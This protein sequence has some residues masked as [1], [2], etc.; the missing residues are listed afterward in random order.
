M[1]QRARHHTLF[2]SNVRRL[3]VM[4]QQLK[5]LWHD[6]VWSKVIAGVILAAGAAIGAYFLN[7]WSAIGTFFAS[8]GDFARAPTSIPN[9]GLLI[10]G[11]L[12]LPTVVLLS[13]LA[14]QA[15]YPQKS[16]PLSWRTYTTD[17][18]FGL[19]WRWRYLDDGLIYDTHTFCPHCDFQVYAQDVS[20]YRFIDHIAFHCD[21]CGRHLGEFQESPASLENKTKRF[22]QQKI[23]N[24]SWLAPSGT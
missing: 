20:S 4:V 11:L 14:W 12:S 7:W 21:S 3:T 24:G 16:T 5:K 1:L 22:I 2:I 9:W 10:L 15:V 18:Y 19:R 17:I 6:P 13:A 23:R 8:A